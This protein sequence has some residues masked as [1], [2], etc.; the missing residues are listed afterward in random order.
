MLCL[1]PDKR[2]IASK[3]VHHNWLDG[4]VVQGEFDVIRR[5]EEDEARRKQQEAVGSAFVGG[6]M[7]QNPQLK[8]AL[9]QSMVDTM[10]P[11]SM[12]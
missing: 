11:V 3:I 7:S 8:A 5:M 1:N 9:D 4:I 12:H 10:R 6:N 2:A